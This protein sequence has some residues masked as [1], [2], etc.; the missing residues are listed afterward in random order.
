MFYKVLWFL[1][2]RIL[3]TFRFCCCFSVKEEMD[4]RREDL[5]TLV[6]W[7]DRHSAWQIRRDDLDVWLFG[8]SVLLL[9]SLLLLL[10]LLSRLLL[11][12]RFFSFRVGWALKAL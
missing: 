8:P 1:L 6:E 4:A 10:Q 3:R 5:P 7:T 11:F 2:V 12:L 9:L